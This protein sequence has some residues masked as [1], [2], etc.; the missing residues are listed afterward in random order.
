MKKKLEEDT[1]TSLPVE[2]VKSRCNKLDVLFQKDKRRLDDVLDLFPEN[3]KD[4]LQTISAKY[5]SEDCGNPYIS[6]ENNAQFHDLE[7]LLEAN[8]ITRHPHDPKQIR[9]SNFL[10]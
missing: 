8:I 10:E 6:F 1:T 3:L 4:I 9:L 7:L 5:F 2:S